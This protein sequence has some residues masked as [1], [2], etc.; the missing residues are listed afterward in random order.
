MSSAP[1]PPDLI[2]LLSVDIVGSAAFKADAPEQQ[3]PP[4]WVQAF[5]AFYTDLPLLIEQA[6]LELSGDGLPLA[7]RLQLWK[8]IGDQLVFLARP[9]DPHQLEGEC[10]A[11]LQ[12]LR[13]AHRLMHERW[14]FGL[15][16]V[17]WA[18]QEQG[19]NVVFR[20]QQQQ[21]SGGSG[22]DLIGPDVDL[23]FRLVA[24]APEGELLVPLEL[25]RLLPRQRLAMQ[26]IG[27]ASLKG[28]RLDPYPL[29]QLQAV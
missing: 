16:G 8:A 18:F 5:E 1:F 15:H 2:L 26:L 14:G 3:G 10:L 9:A 6:R 20:F 27:E 28:I 21:L 24:L 17:A 29:L 7:E 13:Q 4:R 22:F 23:G 19:D 11:F 25:R 12:A